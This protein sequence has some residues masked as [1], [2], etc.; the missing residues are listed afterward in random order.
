MSKKD[1]GNTYTGVK[2]LQPVPN[3][4]SSKME[5]RKLYTQFYFF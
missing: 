5:N 3:I 2:L 4:P 1:P